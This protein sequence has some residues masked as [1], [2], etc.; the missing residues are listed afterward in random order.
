MNLVRKRYWLFLFSLLVTIPGLV[1]LAIPPGLRAGIEFAGGSSLTVEFA[2]PVSEGQV[3][4]QVAALGYPEAIVQRLGDSS[5]FIQTR[6]LRE[7][8]LD[9]LG[10]VLEPGERE[11]LQGALE[12]NLAPIETAEFASVSPL[13]AR[14][15]VRN[16]TI[17]VVAAS[18]AILLYIAWAF[19]SLPNP[20][21]YGVCA[22]IAMLH[23]VLVVLGLFSI[24]GR[25][26]NIEVNA[27]FIT[28]VLTVVGYSVN[29]TVV[30]FDRIRENLTRQ[31]AEDLPATVNVSILETL[32]RSLNTAMTTLFVVVAL[33]LFGGPS[34]LVLVLSLLIGIATGTYSSIAIAS[35]LLVSWESHD[36]GRFWRRL[37]PA[38]AG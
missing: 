23:D 18:I 9:P 33:L 28:G 24:L 6:T 7:A 22:V 26:M 32:G 11:R 19:R 35:A 36:L 25:F 31:V 13:V 2:Q 21:R 5:Y 20:F 10:N 14:E 4:D 1:S 16:A 30:V 34:I 37:R 8:R 27:M 29:D 3:R 15:T 17:A 12:Q 38:P